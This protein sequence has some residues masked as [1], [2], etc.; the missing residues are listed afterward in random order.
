LKFDS[1]YGLYGDYTHFEKL[2]EEIVENFNKN[3]FSLDYLDSIIREMHRK[4]NSI[5]LADVSA[6][7]SNTYDNIEELEK[8]FPFLK[9]FQRFIYP[10]L[11]LYFFIHS[12]YENNQLVRMQNMNFA[13]HL[14]NVIKNL[15][16][17]AKMESFSSK[18]NFEEFCD[19]IYKHMKRAFELRIKPSKQKMIAAGGYMCLLANV[20]LL[21]SESMENKRKL[22]QEIENW[23]LLE[24]NFSFFLLNMVS[25]IESTDSSL[26]FDKFIKI[27]KF[28][29]LFTQ[30]AKEIEIEHKLLHTDCVKADCNNNMKKIE[31][32][33]INL[34][35]CLKIIKNK[36]CRKG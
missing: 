31:M 3:G 1:V 4:S 29:R 15:L 6:T 22:L 12:F 25:F 21:E 34:S 32:L 28:V 23:S 36:N 10:T 5:K 2:K 8:K 9:K 11:K 20:C 33:F 19:L 17:I 18:K 30:K 27:A 35:R 13:M 14:F 16:A 7:Y 26:T 24:E